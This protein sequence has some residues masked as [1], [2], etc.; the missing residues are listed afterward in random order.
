MTSPSRDLDVQP[1]ALTAFAAASRDRATRF[2]ELHRG[3]RD[4][5]VSRHS[6]GV[7]PASFSLAAA[8]AEQFEACLQGLEEGAEVMADIAEGLTDTADAY[9]GTDVATTDMFTPGA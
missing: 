3:F 1:E 7:M 5:H 6:F 2:R 9:T 4:G 8:Y